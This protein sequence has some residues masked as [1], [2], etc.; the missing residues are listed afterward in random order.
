MVQKPLW[1][2]L[3][4]KSPLSL[5]VF[6]CRVKLWALFSITP[7]IITAIKKEDASRRHGELLYYSV[8]PV[9][10]PQSCHTL[11]GLSPSLGQSADQNVFAEKAVLYWWYKLE[12]MCLVLI[13]FFGFFNLN[14]RISHANCPPRH[15]FSAETERFL[16]LSSSVTIWK[17][18]KVETK[19]FFFLHNIRHH[20][21]YYQK[22]ITEP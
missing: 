18:R 2:F 15:S 13:F 3:L 9:W 5:L 11:D 10:L 6:G 4:D 17:T 1:H 7:Q 14:I 16:G 21:N 20:W 22:T 8:S 19:L 12:S